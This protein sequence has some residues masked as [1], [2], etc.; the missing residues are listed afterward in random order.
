MYV[1]SQFEEK[2]IDVLH[3]LIREHSLGTLVTLASEGLNANHIPFELDPETGQFGTL[4][5]H[6]ARSNPVWRD[7]SEK[8]DALV[9]FQGAQAYISP[10][11][12]ATKQEGGKVVPTY[13]YMVVHASGPMRVID[14]PVW[15]HGLLERL[16]DRYES[17][18]TEPWR[19]S[20]APEDFI[21]KL[22]PAIVG[23]E[24]PIAKLVGKWKVSQNQPR[25]NREGV[26]KGLQEVGG[27]NAVI[28]A[29][30]LLR[31]NER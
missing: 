25:A 4:R 15:L 19:L 3:Q 5:A 14:D 20:D 6:V 27:D 2:R 7:F 31:E 18:R 22:L 13:N 1:P 11:W 8:L 30:A 26:V 28:M 10:S 16:S 12:Y 21:A 24:I 9:V 17:G 23:I 29:Q